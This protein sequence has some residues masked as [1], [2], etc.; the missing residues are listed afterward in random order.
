MLYVNLCSAFISL[1]TLISSGEL[2]SSFVF[3]FSHFDF[4]VNSL[5]LSFAASFGQMIILITIKE[6]GALFFATVMTVRQV[7]SII[8][9]CFIY[10]H[11]LTWKQW[12]SSAVVFGIL[13]WKDAT[14]SSSRSHGHS[15]KTIPTTVTPTSAASS[16]SND[17][18]NVVIDNSK[19]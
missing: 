7:V 14:R 4:F 18:V 1:I 9:S 16:N 6:F 2:I 5:I 13:Y 15:H 8:L 11:P 19:K 3:S 17:T 10:M 12:L